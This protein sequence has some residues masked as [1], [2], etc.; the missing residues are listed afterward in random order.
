M[1]V[2]ALRTNLLP[3]FI[4]IGRTVVKIWQNESA[5]AGANLSNAGALQKY[6]S[7]TWSAPAL[8]ASPL[9]AWC[10]DSNSTYARGTTV[11]LSSP[12]ISRRVLRFYWCV[13]GHI[14]ADRHFEFYA[15]N[16]AL[17]NKHRHLSRGSKE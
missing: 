5:L 3:K 16:L 8:D 17:R 14:D 12:L 10:K 13:L 11:S 2:G 15:G 6:V 4:I 7:K 1:R 9:V